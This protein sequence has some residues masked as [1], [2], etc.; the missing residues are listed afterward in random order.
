MTK[1]T[2]SY[3]HKLVHDGADF[4]AYQCNLG[5]GVWRTVSVWMIPQQAFWK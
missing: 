4:V 1:T 5:D 3:R 2:S